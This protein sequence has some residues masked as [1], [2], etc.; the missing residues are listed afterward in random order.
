MT[1][2]PGGFIDIAQ[3]ARKVVF[4]GTFEARGAKF[5]SG[6]GQ[7]RI[8]RYGEICKLVDQV[9]QITFSG[10]QARAQA[11]EVIYVTE[12]CVFEL[13]DDGL[14]LTEIAPGVDLKRDIL[15][16]MRF[17]PIVNS[18]PRRMH[19]RCFTDQSG[20]TAYV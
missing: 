12:R 8:E 4:C 9:E 17:S 15:D 7:L 13:R 5:V 3:N 20:E 2:G 10:E 1:V 6:D 19:E 16:R 11:Q 14:H 18:A